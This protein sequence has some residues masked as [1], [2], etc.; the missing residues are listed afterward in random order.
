MKHTD[1]VIIELSNKKIILLI[2]GSITF[3]VLSVWLLTI[4]PQSIGIIQRL[5]SPIL[6]S[7]VAWAGIIFFGLCGLAGVKK[8]FDNKP[9]LIINS[10]GIED[11]SS[12]VVVGVVPWKDVTGIS[13]YQ[14]Q[15]QKL[16]SV[17]VADTEK[18]A[19]KGGVVK[20]MANR[21]TIKMCG[22]P[23]NIS[24]SSLKIKHDELFKLLNE[25]YKKSKLI[26]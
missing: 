23:I 3:V 20:Q 4:D 2:L 8:L 12:A 1:E 13:E 14:V 6:I 22:T 15:G 26:N 11:N 21:A 5:G 16:V 24:S 10:A 25:F 19:N 17:L 18:Y 7:I 9:G